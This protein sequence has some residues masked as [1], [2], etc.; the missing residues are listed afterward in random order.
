M[1][2]Q[3]FHCDHET[4]QARLVTFYKGNEEQNE[5]LCHEC[6]SEWL[7]SIKG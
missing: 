7:Q 4:E 5:L 1:A 2:Y 3:C 6:Y